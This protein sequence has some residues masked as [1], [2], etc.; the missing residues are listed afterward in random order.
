MAA[1]AAV[2]AAEESRRCSA[3]GGGGG[4]GVAALAAARAASR[5]TMR[6]RAARLSAAAAAAAIEGCGSDGGDGRASGGE[7]RAALNCLNA[8]PCLRSTGSARKNMTLS[9]LSAARGETLEALLASG[10]EPSVSHSS[11]WVSFR[12]CCCS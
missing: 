3:E 1:A 4:G 8:G 12:C 10:W 2:A 9:K 11:S 5:H 6:M 7:A